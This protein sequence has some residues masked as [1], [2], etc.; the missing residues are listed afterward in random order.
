MRAR[1]ER[2][3]KEK[4]IKITGKYKTKTIDKRA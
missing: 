3:I 4:I 2:D 1:H